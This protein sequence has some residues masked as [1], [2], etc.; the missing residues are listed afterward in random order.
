MPVVWMELARGTLA[1]CDAAEALSVA[2]PAGIPG[3]ELFYEHVHL[4]PNGNYALALAWA[5]Q[6]EK[7]L[8][9]ALKRGAQP[10]WASQA[11]CEGWLGLTDWNRVSIL[12]DVLQR[13]QR[14]PFSAQTGAAQRVARLRNEITETRQ[15]LTEGAAAQ[16]RETY[17]RALGRA[18]DDFRLHANYA[19]FLEARHELKPAIAERKAV[20]ELIPD[21][22][23]PYYCLGV[24]LKE[25]G[26]LAE[27]RE[28]LLKAAAMKP[29]EGDV[30][31]ELGIVCA[32]QADWERARRELQVARRFSPEDPQA[33]LFLGEVLWKLGRQSEAMASLREAIRLAPSDW[34]PHYRL[35][36]DSAQQGQLSEAATEYREAIRLNPAGVKARLG[37]ATVLLNL[38]RQ[39]EASQQLDEALKLEPDN[40]AAL[41]LRRKLRRDAAVTEP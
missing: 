13:I 40:Q 12:E 15:R 8:S 25:A 1:L 5:G 19:E 20:C 33:A 34:Q 31:L 11:E 29:D 10:S 3:E 14:P 24:D 7:V 36:S 6:I 27:A 38:G 37:L 23:F 41:E 4:N 18:P 35:A 9:P 17:V 30:W 21:Y 32:R 39:L 26:A 16:A 22:Y 28:A 2:S